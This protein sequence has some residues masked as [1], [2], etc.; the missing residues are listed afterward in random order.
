MQTR[1]KVEQIKAY[2]SAVE[3]PHNLLQKAVTKTQRD[4]D[5]DGASLGWVCSVELASKLSG[6][7]NGKPAQ[8]GMSLS[9]VDSHLRKLLWV[10]CTHGHARVKGND[11]ADT[12]AGKEAT[13]TSGL[14]NLARKI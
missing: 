9:M 7:W 10:S 12:L 4:A 8:T 14:R 1:Q 6:K 13:I 11:R 5:W 2:F 3:N